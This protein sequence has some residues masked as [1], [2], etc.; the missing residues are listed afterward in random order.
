ML[1]IFLPS[2][3]RPVRPSSSLETKIITSSAESIP[4]TGELP[5][6]DAFTVNLEISFL[7]G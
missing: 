2:K 1:K 3:S 7:D 5:L 6:T 4:V